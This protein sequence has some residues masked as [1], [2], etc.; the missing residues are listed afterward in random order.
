MLCDSR[1]EV[2]GTTLIFNRIEVEDAGVY[3]CVARNRIK[4]A[5]SPAEVIVSGM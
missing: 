2:R 5:K 1:V 3:E 4:S